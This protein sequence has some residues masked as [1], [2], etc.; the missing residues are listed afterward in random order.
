MRKPVQWMTLPEL[1]DEVDPTRQAWETTDLDGFLAS[2]QLL[3]LSQN[4]HS[5]QVVADELLRRPSS[6]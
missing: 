5:H 3:V 2:G 1:G 4:A 6:G